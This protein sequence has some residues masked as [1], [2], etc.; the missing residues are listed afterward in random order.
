MDKQKKRVREKEKKEVKEFIEKDPKLRKV[1]QFRNTLIILGII[2]LGFSLAISYQN[3]LNMQPSTPTK[4]L[5]GR[6]RSVRGC[7]RLEVLARK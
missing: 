2:I 7:L 1:Y 5:L 4:C 3:Y 6:S